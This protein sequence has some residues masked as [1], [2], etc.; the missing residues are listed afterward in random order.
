MARAQTAQCSDRRTE[1][2][3]WWYLVPVAIVFWIAGMAF[4][5]FLDE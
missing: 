5:G 4:Q 3:E 1:M 2:I